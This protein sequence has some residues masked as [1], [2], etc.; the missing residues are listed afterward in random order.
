MSTDMEEAREMVEEEREEE[1]EQGRSLY[2]F[3]NMEP[4]LLDK[5]LDYMTCRVMAKVSATCFPLLSDK[6]GEYLRP[7]IYHGVL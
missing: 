3:L 6:V 1:M 7:Q 5:V 2:P 4:H